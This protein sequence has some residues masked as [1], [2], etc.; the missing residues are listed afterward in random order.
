MG[1]RESKNHF[2][3]RIFFL[4]GVHF[5]FFNF[6]NHFWCLD[7]VLSQLV[8]FLSFLSVFNKDLK[9]VSLVDHQQLSISYTFSSVRYI[10]NFSQQETMIRNGFNVQIKG[11]VLITVTQLKDPQ[12]WSEKLF[13]MFLLKWYLS[14]LNYILKKMG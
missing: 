14:I 11:Y 7:A 4:I 13:H 1:C 12:G 5:S 10:W 6:S 9:L 2:E 8:I 3:I